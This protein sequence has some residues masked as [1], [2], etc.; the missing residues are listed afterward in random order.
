MSFLYTFKHSQS[1][2][3]YKMANLAEIYSK[4]KKCVIFGEIFKVALL[5]FA[6]STSIPEVISCEPDHLGLNALQI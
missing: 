1:F 3:P 4:L 2:Y 6:N 5:N